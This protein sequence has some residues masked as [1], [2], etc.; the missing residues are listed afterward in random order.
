VIVA[1]LTYPV[2]ARPAYPRLFKGFVAALV[3]VTVAL[4]ATHLG[5]LESA[6][7]KWRFW[8]MVGLTLAAATR[9]FV[10]A[11][12][13]GTAMVICPTL[14]FTSAILLCWGLGPAIVVEAV[15]TVV[16]AWRLRHNVTQLTVV[17]GQYTVAFAAAYVVLVIGDP[18]PFEHSG[19]LATVLDALTVAG[20]AAAWLATYSLLELLTARVRNGPRWRRAVGSL[21]YQSLFQGALLMLAP[22]LAVSAHVNA[23]FVPLI[24]LPLYAVERMARLSAERDQA[25]RLDAV[26]GLVNRTGLQ[27][28]FTDLSEQCQ[29][30]RPW[31]RST[32][33]L[34]LLD[35]DRFK[36]VNDTLGHEAGDQLLIVVAHR[37]ET[38]APAGSVVARLGGDEFAVLATGLDCQSAGELA[39]RIATAL[40]E[41]ITMP[42]PGRP[43]HHEGLPIDITASVGIALFPEHGEDFPTLMRH[44][45]VAMYDAKQRGDTVAFYAA[46]GDPNSPHRLGLLGDLRRALQT[47]DRTELALHYQPQVALATGEVVGVEA[48]LRWQ[49]PD[50]GPVSPQELLHVAEQTA[51]MQSITARVIDDVTAQVAAWNNNGVRLRASLNVSA[52]DIH[53]GDLVRHL[54]TR[55]NRCAV[56]ASQIQ[57]EITESAL[58]ADPGRALCTLNEISAL[59]IAVALDD[60]GTGY[61]SLQN[62]RKLPFAEVKIDRSFVAGMAHNSDDAAIVRSTVELARALGLRT[63]AEGVENEY[64]WRLLAELGCGVGQG[65]YAARPMPGDQ[66]PGWLTNYATRPLVS[67]Q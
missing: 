59:G 14:C 55:L 24:F 63:V 61:S 40:A 7:G 37:L 1:A 46:E 19:G 44:A 51:V 47:R 57:L 25:T 33:A 15:A 65:W 34:L 56:P 29:A 50:R 64:T 35:L 32:L 10:T 42:R 17:I 22:V 11:G 45:D 26:T 23:A 8:L 18:E 53:H 3:V 28:R 4:T 38:V 13:R 58:L 5:Q 2:A 41:P 43:A 6:A 60:F 52:R 12:N 48:L 9:A 36:H 27:I 31:N 30:E 20:A 49:H 16:V 62:L 54:A 21:G 39:G 66:I 67:T